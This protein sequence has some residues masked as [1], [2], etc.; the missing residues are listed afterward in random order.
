MEKIGEVIP[1]MF[2]LQCFTNISIPNNTIATIILLYEHQSH[3]QEDIF[4]FSKRRLDM[5]FEIL[6]VR[7]IISL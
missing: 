1:D 3:H 4:S 7:V 6:A 2:L 5:N